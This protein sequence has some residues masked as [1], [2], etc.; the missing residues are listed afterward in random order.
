VDIRQILLGADSLGFDA[1]GVEETISLPL[2]E[3]FIRL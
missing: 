3:I 1:V 2:E